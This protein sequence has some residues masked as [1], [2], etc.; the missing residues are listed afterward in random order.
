MSASAAQFQFAAEFVTFLVAAAGL[1]L[2]LLRSELLTEAGWARAVLALGLACMGS[3][4]FLHGSR[5]VTRADH[6]GLLALGAGA[7]LLLAVGSLRWRGERAAGRLLQVGVALELAALALDAA[8]AAT[9]PSEAV[10]GVGAAIIGAGLVVASRRAIAA[11]VAAS[12]ALTLLLVVLVLSVALSAV[13]TS[14][15]R[16]QAVSRLD[17]RARGEATRAAQSYTP[18]LQDALVASA[19]VRGAHKDEEAAAGNVTTLAQYVT[20]LQTTFLKQ[21]ALVWL[22]PSR[23]VVAVANSSGLAALSGDRGLVLALAGSPVVDEAVRNSAQEGS[24]LTIGTH[25]LAV[26]ASPAFSGTPPEL[27]GVAVAVRPLDERYMTIEASDDPALSL[28][29]VGR[30]ATVARY[31][32]QPSDRVLLSLA[33]AV[34]DG[35][36]PGRARTVGGRYVV[37]RPVFSQTNVPVAA[38]V[39]STPT[40][41][42]T[43]TRDSLFRTLFSIALGGTLLALLLAAV[44][45]DR[46]GAGLRRLTVAARGI[47][48]GDVGVRTGFRGEDE[49]GLLGAAFD[50]MAG[51]IEEKTAALLRAADDETRLRNRLEAVVAGMGE[52]LVAVGADGSVTDVN[53]AGEELLGVIAADVRGRPATEVVALVGDDGSDLREQLRPSPRRWSGE[54]FVEQDDGTRVPVAVSAGVIRGPDQEVTGRVFVL[55]DLRREREVE[56]MKTEFLSRVGHELRTPLA[57][58]VGFAR[59]L[60]TRT[61]PARQARGWHEDILEQSKRLERI[62]EMLE[63]FASLGAG[64]VPLRPEPVDLRELVHDVA[65]RWGE[66]LDGTHPLVRRVARD[67]PEVMGDRQWLGRALDELIDNAVKF[68]P[69]GGRVAVNV[70]PVEGA[71]EVEVSVTDQGKGMTE[72]E[73]AQAFGE[74]VQG[75][76]SDTRSFGGLGLGLSLV[77]RV[78]EGHGGRLICKSEAGRGSKLSVLLPVVPINDADEARPSADRAL[79]G[80]RVRG[81]MRPSRA[82]G[83]PGAARGQ[84]S[85]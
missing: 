42:V 70:A 55:R 85:S 16:D 60:A 28:A 65:S 36:S 68:S 62:V 3:G 71:D 61:V 34:L 12:A 44:V 67:T 64:W 10:R 57:G 32:A 69:G 31:G 49:V 73:R 8:Q 82:Q 79:R 9:V 38:L 45:G 27:R 1:A 72:L 52:A 4:A 29:F 78:A 83:R 17:S 24:V 30:D 33:R 46:I 63:F 15:V 20:T 35:G 66:R 48:R 22:S 23:Q 11:R 80:A 81:G 19:S 14:T 21:D 75:D 74:F 43:R 56:R 6:P 53:Q 25:V 50:S 7:V 54:G 41:A 51:S 77:Q 59:L 37:V 84:R 76:M 5:L 58:I 26:A 47:Q 18:L 39:A 13:L 40:T 2:V